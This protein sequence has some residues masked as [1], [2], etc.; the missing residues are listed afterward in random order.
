MQLMIWLFWQYDS[1]KNGVIFVSEPNVSLKTKEKW[2][3][4]NK[5]DVAMYIRNNSVVMVAVN[6]YIF[7]I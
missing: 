4:D 6:A 2:L 7:Y 1:S 3:L 5:K